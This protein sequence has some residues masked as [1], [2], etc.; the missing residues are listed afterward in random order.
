[1][2]AALLAAGTPVSAQV[3]PVTSVAVDCTRGASL[4]RALTLGDERKP[5][6]VV[7]RGTCAESVVV[8]RSDVTLRA[9]EPGAGLAGPDAAVDTITVTGSRVTLEG[10]T[11]TGGRNGVA[12]QSAAGL[13]LRGLA[14]SRTGRS[15]VVVLSGA[16]AVVE[17]CTIE[18]NPRDGIAFDAG[19][20]VVL[21]STISSNGR[22]GI[23][24]F[25]NGA[26]RIGL[27]PSNEP[28]GNVISSN[29]ASGILSAVGGT[30]ALAM[31]EVSGNG[32]DK[33][34]TSRSG[35]GVVGGSATII[36]GNTISANASSGVAA[37]RSAS[38]T[39][40]EAGY[41]PIPATNVVSGNGTADQAGGVFAFQGSSIILRNAT[42][43]NNLGFG[44]GVSLRSSGQL[45]GSTLSGNGDNVRL[46]MGGGLYVGPPVSTLSGANNGI[47]CFDGE[48]S[49]V[50]RTLLSFSGNV[51]DVAAGCTGF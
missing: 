26:A 13:V 39:I 11:V 20:G 23:T 27:D 38:V 31:T 24:L 21:S 6:E 15:G 49:Y 30:F 46:L 1:M 9:A 47:Q 41:G 7:V 43:T 17:G 10:L 34:A 19:S 14:V 35:V 50:N 33:T 12:A 4:G 18:L 45:V 48:A 40:G 37:F 3:T 2:V 22:Y 32:W 25:N 44:F 42:V 28:G 8:D 5:L 51:V 36:G 29:G 16:S